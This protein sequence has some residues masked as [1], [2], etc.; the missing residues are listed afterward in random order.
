MIRGYC[1]LALHN[2]NI[3]LLKIRINTRVRHPA[4]NSFRIYSRE[5]KLDKKVK[6]RQL[7]DNHLD[8]ITNV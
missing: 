6:M 3:S 8:N 7:T 1:T 4:Q 5:I 2:H